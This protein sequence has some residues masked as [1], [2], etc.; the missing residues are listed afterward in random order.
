MTNTERA[1]ALLKKM[2]LTEK[3]GQLCMKG[4]CNLDAQGVP[5]SLDLVKQIEDGKI[6][7]IIQLAHDMSETTDYLQRIAVEKTR[8]KIPLLINADMVHGLET[9]Y[10]VPIA[11]SCSFDTDLVERCAKAQAEETTICGIRYTNAPM[12]DIARDARWGRIVESQGEDPYLAGEMAKAYVRGLQN[13][14]NYVMA[15]LKH[16]VGYGACEGA[17]DYNI[18]EMSENTMLNTYLIPFREGVKQGCDSIMT[19]FTSIENVPATG[20]KKYLRDIL[21][22]KFGFNGIIISD[23]IS[24]Y[25]MIPFGYCK[26]LRD[27]AYKCIVAGLDV[28]LGSDVYPFELERLVLDGK[29][30]ESLVDEAA[31]RIL[32]KKF[33]LG[34]FENPYSQPERKDKIMCE[35]YLE[36]SYKMALESA[37]LLENDGVLPLNKDKKIAVIGKFSN[38]RDV[39]GSWQE[40]H[41]GDRAVTLREGLA[42][43]GFNIISVVDGYDVTETTKAIKNADVVLF[44]F[45]ETS[46]ES[47]EARSRH[48]LHV[49]REVEECYEVIKEQNKKV[50]SLIFTGRPLVIN[51]VSSSNALVMCWQL[52]HRMGDAIANLLSGRENFSAK[53]SV[54]IP[55]DEGQ[56][57]IYYAIKKLGR[58]YQPNNS[59]W[60]FQCRYDDGENEPAYRF[61]YGKSYS[62]FN[63]GEIRLD[64]TEMS[65]DDKITVSVD[66]SNDGEVKGVEIVQLYIND[67]LSEVVRPIKELKD[68]KRVEIDS[69]QTVKVE[70]VIDKE[71]LEYYHS[72]GCLKADVG[73]FEVYVGADSSVENKVKFTL[74]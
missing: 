53:L 62:N 72:N 4:A 20:N 46:E 41:F 3:V 59:E 65:L 73:D 45:G 55:K 1:E 14:D 17:R 49:N 67:C 26:D 58:P 28:D 50:I 57:P 24:A 30:P 68:F 25:E 15:T 39:L 11:T 60:R 70:F 47:G 38:S 64:K 44:N 23:A 66:V 51:D 52:G 2:T 32:T 34:L 69:H 29:I 5:D 21:R 35:E 16:F 54:T 22:D 42:K 12:I 31:L 19:A 56:L 37:V 33:D 63:Y 8:L 74:K 13:E 36:L 27:C 61:G 7:N 10:P 43:E 40:S 9:I 48:N 6:G 71:K 18:C